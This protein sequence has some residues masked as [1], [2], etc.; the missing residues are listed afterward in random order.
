VHTLDPTV[1]LSYTERVT[2]RQGRAYNYTKKFDAKE[3][4][5]VSTG[6]S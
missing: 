4:K 2:G 6:S 5:T 1:I 3:S